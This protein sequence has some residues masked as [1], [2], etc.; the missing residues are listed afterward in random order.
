MSVYFV[1]TSALGRR[2]LPETG[3]KWVRTWIEPNAGHVI[4]ISQLTEIDF[5]THLTRHTGKGA[6]TSADITTLMNHFA[7][8]VAKQYLSIML[9][10]ALIS[11][12][13]ALALKYTA[14]KTSDALQLASALQAVKLLNDK[15]IFISEQKDLLEAATAEDFS[16]DSPLN[17]P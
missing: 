4:V 8:H 11:Q 17:H 14:L 9:D 16:T 15:A 13:Q 2:Y 7:T 10:T 1:D 6:L 5:V 12:A 3:A